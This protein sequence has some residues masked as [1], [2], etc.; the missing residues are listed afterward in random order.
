MQQVDLGPVMLMVTE[1]EPVPPHTPCSV[2]HAAVDAF[3]PG[4][5]SLRVTHS[6]RGVPQV[7]ERGTVS[8]TVLSAARRLL[9]VVVPSFQDASRTRFLPAASATQL[10]ST[11]TVILARR[12]AGL[13]QA[14]PVLQAAV[15]AASAAT[16]K[17]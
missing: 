13:Q 10:G 5:S 7:T 1:Q 4:V 12:D 15:A 2:E 9:S 14:E 17:Q 16:V 3:V 6:C 11:A 8:C